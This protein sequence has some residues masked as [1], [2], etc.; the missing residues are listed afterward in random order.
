MLLLYNTYYIEY[1]YEQNGETPY[2]NSIQFEN[3]YKNEGYSFKKYL[4]QKE[5][6]EYNH[7]FFVKYSIQ[8]INDSTFLFTQYY[9]KEELNFFTPFK[10]YFGLLTYEMKNVS[11]FYLN[12]SIAFRYYDREDELFQ[13]MKPDPTLKEIFYPL[14]PKTRYIYSEGLL[15]EIN[16]DT[17]YF[18][19]EKQEIIDSTKFKFI[20]KIYP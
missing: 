12:D 10:Y 2:Y 13:F 3:S 1:F 18:S 4:W 20:N 16:M 8:F 7:L 17:I 9:D 19:I 11:T 5:C 14:S 6:I 15:K